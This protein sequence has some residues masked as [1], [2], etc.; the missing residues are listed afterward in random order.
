MQRGSDKHGPVLDEQMQHEVD[1]MVRGNK[2]TRVHEELETEPTVTD[3]GENVFDRDAVHRA[4]E[5]EE[6][7]DE[8]E[9]RP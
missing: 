1:G 7:A 8:N 4:E 2:P 6:S 3:D 5:A 9:E